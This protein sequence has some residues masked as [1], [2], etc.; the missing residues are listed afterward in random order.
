MK[1]VRDYLEILESSEDKQKALK[2]LAKMKFNFKRK[3]MLG[4]FLRVT[5]AIARFDFNNKIEEDV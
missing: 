4:E 2:R 5:E 1:T 3:R